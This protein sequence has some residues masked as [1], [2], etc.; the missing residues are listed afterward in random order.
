MVQAEEEVVGI[1]E[2]EKIQERVYIGRRGRATAHVVL[3]NAF[4]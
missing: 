4:H 2:E 3:R 1:E